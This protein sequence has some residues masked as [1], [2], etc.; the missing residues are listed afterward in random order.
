VPFHAL[1]LPYIGSPTVAL[2]YVIGGAG[3]HG[4]PDLTQNV[5]IRIQLFILR[6]DGVIDPLTH[7]T[8]IALSGAV[9]H[10]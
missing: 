1:A 6:V 3:V 2:R 8:A 5:G 7:R 9:P 10:A 4:L